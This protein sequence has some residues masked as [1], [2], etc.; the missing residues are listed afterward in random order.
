MTHS[1]L[2]FITLVQRNIKPPNLEQVFCTHCCHIVA[3]CRQKF[4]FFLFLEYQVYALLK[5]Y[6]LKLFES[7]GVSAN[8]LLKLKLPIVETTK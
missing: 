8:Y 6:V 4:N 1:E 2:S 3:I 5:N 7:L